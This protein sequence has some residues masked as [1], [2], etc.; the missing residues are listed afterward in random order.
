MTAPPPVDVAE[1][2]LWS[3]VVGQDHVVSQLR[4][5]ISDPVHAYLLVGPEGS[6]KLAAAKAFAAE[7]LADGL[8]DEGA[9]R[10]HR[11]VAVD[12]HPSLIQFRP[13]GAKFLLEQAQ[14]VALAASRKPPEGGR[15]VL[16]LHGLE[17]PSDGTFERMLKAIEEPAPGTFFLLPVTRVPPEMATVA[18]RCVRLDLGPV[19]ERL[20]AQRLV[21]EGVAAASA[22]LAASLSGGSLS[23]ARLLANDPEVGRRRQLWR[24]A[25]FGLDGT[26]S[27]AAVAADQLLEAIDGLLEPLAARHAEELDA[28]HASY[29]AVDE[30]P[31]KG[32][33]KELTDRHKREVKKVRLDELRA[34]LATIV[35]VYRERMAEG[36]P[37]EDFLLVAERVQQLCDALEFNPGEALQLRAL[38]LELPPLR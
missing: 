8:D 1:G 2:D 30:T 37:H 3:E 18:S 38:L 16:L 13:T 10:A 31:P 6:G 24:D 27:A 19:S 25:P 15:Q 17:N 14:Q 29:E 26:G 23:R 22:R 35:E 12:E 21:D 33:T 32:R 9:R 7:L 20:L 4:A 34:G 36:G 11:L 28:F 5:A